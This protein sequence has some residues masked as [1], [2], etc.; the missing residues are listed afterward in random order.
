MELKRTSHA[1]YDTKYHLVWVPKYRKWILRRDIRA[2]IK[3]IF[4]EISSNHDFEIDTLEVAEDHVHIF[5]SFPPRHS[6]SKVVGMLK[7]IS[8]SVIFQEH[9]EVKQE[10]WGREFWEDGYF[11]R[12]VGDKVT[13]EVIRKYIKY[14]RE[15]EKSPK[16]N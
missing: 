12:T 11:V 14:H 5:L 9:P 8:A 3:E 2:R 15:H 6:I 10:L 1:V 16:L 4:K 13:K 7:S